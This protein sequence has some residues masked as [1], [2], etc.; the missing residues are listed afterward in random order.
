MMGQTTGNEISLVMVT[1]LWR[2]PLGPFFVQLREE[3]GLDSFFKSRLRQ[4][5]VE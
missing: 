2:E 5:H 3:M 4:S 1:S